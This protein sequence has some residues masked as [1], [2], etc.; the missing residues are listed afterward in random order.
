MSATENLAG[1]RD[2]E[3]VA[4]RRRIA[5]IPDNQFDWS[6]FEKSMPPEGLS[7]RH[8]ARLGIYL[9]LLNIPHRGA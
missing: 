3:V 2:R 8:Q 5:R 9:R 1:E 7:A 4:A 6:L